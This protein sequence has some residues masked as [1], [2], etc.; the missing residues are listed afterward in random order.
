MFHSENR[1]I[2]MGTREQH[3]DP[4]MEIHPETARELGIANSDW[5]YIET[6][7]GVIRQRALVTNTIHPRVVSIEAH[8]WFPE[9][10]GQEPWLHGLWHSNANVLTMIDLDSCDPVTG[11]WPM[12][13]LLCKVYKAL[14]REPKVK[15]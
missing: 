9:E 8:W 13:G 6:R 15:T 7:R 11:G 5:A 2:G 1:H 10:P 14:S 12:R 3:P 4:L